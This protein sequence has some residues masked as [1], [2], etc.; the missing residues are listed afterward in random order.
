[1]GELILRT[2]SLR[3][4]H[5][6]AARTE[7]EQPNDNWSA[8]FDCKYIFLRREPGIAT[9]KNQILEKGTNYGFKATKYPNSVGG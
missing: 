1:M 5:C 3:R 9:R 8:H 6:P 4:N 7:P 2:P